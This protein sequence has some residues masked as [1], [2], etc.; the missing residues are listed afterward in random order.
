[1]LG[2]TV[3][4]YALKFNCEAVEWIADAQILPQESSE[5]SNARK[6]EKG[7]SSGGIGQFT[8]VGKE[9]TTI[10]LPTPLMDL[11]SRLY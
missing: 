10:G 2:S 8:G 3:R 11:G 1:M 4:N 7:N 9:W 6:V 5:L